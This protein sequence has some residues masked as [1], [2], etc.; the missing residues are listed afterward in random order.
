MLRVHARHIKG[1]Q[2]DVREATGEGRMNE[3]GCEEFFFLED[4]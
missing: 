3:T 1:Y 2:F 4:V